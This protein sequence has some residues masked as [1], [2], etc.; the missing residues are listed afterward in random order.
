MELCTGGSLFN[1]MEEYLQ[2]KMTLKQILFILKDITKALIKMHAHQIAH[3]DLKIENVL[4]N[5]KKFKLCDFGSAS[6]LEIDFKTI[7]K[8]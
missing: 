6:D 1:L 7:S 2:T 8:N 4:L 3:R 5:N